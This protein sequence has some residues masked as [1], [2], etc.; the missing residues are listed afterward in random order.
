MADKKDPGITALIAVVGMLVLQAPAIAYFYLGKM[1]KGIEYLV[2]TWVL[3]GIL[4]VVYTGGA[5][6]TGGLGAICL[7]PIFLLYALFELAIVY[8]AYLMAKGE[9]PK[10]PQI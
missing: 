6:V 7:L 8:D 2:A 5:I 9:K 1:R 3:L 10:L 4:V